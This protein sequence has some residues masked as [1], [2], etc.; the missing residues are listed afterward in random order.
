[1]N[2]Y[3]KDHAE[4]VHDNAATALIMIVMILAMLIGGYCC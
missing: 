4:S 1:M 3:Q 2:K